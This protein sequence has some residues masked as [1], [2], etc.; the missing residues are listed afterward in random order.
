M[1][2]FANSKFAHKLPICLKYNQHH[3]K[4]E[5]QKTYAGVS[6]YPEEQSTLGLVSLEPIVTPRHIC[7]S[8]ILKDA[9]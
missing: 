3:H 5:N 8:N 4:E 6:F 1:L 2:L 9:L 7:K